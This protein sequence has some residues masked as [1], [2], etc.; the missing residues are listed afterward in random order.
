MQRGQTS[1]NVWHIYKRYNDFVNLHHALQP[2]SVRLPL[3]PKK[4]IGNFDKEFIAERQ[5]GL[6]VTIHSRDCRTFIVY[7][8]IWNEI[9]LFKEVVLIKV[10]LQGDLV[11]WPREF[12][13]NG[14]VRKTPFKIVIKMYKR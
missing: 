7:L 1:D 10:A 5:A 12:I 11:A 13:L 8:I 9:K 6:Q 3:P 14:V 2:S 4:L